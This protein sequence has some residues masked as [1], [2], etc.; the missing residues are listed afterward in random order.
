MPI[1][2]RLY[3]YWPW[4]IR[5]KEHWGLDQSF[6]AQVSRELSDFITHFDGKKDGLWCSVS[7]DELAGA[8]AITRIL[9]KFATPMF[10][11]L[12]EVEIAKIHLRISRRRGE[13]NFIS[14]CAVIQITG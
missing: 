7:K 10:G 3:D 14:P 1:I 6:E 2:N 13:H 11:I 9:C 12:M 4:K 8:I 5:Y